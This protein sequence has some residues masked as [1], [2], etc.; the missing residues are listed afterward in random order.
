MRRNSPRVIIRKL[1]GRRGTFMVRNI[2][3]SLAFYTGLRDDPRKRP[4]GISAMV[5]V[6]NEEEWIEPALL[7]IKDLVDEYVIIDSSNDNTP[8]IIMRLR[9]EAGLNIKYQ[10]SPPGDIASI[11]NTILARTSYR[12]ILVWDGDFVLKE[13]SVGFIKSFIENL[14]PRRHYLIYWPWITLCGDIYHTCSEKPY[15][16]EHWLYTH[17][18]DLRYRHVHVDGA[19]RDTLI[20]PLRLYKAIYIDRIMGVHLVTV[21]K[22]ARVAL[23]SLWYKY[24]SEFYEAARKGISYEE[25][26]S[27]KAKELY[28]TGDLEEVGCMIIRDMIEKLPRYDESKYGGLPSLVIKH[29]E[30]RKYLQCS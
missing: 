12:W 25:Y 8:N 27:L 26:A 24:R 3:S 30:S 16:I 17:S 20:A 15:H 10:W 23:R 4:Q 7:S 9:D 5:A 19:P 18:E 11:R 29:W 21:K 28:G 13:D 1:L 6:Y 2:A 22:P 14:D